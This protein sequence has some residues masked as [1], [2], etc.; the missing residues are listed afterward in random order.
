MKTASP[1][2]LK[3]TLA[4]AAISLAALTPMTHVQADE[5]L[6]F[7]NWSDY[8]AEETIARF[9]KETG[10]KV[11]YDVYDSNETLEAKLLAGN[12]GYDL[13]VPSSHFMALQIK[14]GIFQPLDKGKLSN[15]PHLDA[16]LMKT[17]QAKDPSNQYGVPYL[18]GTTGIGYNPKQVAEVL[19]EDAPVDSWELVFNPKYMEKLA[20]CGVTFLD[21]PDEMFSFAM[22]YAGMDPNSNKRADFKPSSPA[23]K[24]LKAVRPH[25]K[26]FTSSQYINDLA[27][28]DSCVA[29]GFSGD[30]FQA[31]AR[32]EE[33]NNGIEVAY[34]IPKEGT[35]IWFD[36]LLIPADAKNS[37]NAHKFI[38]YLM[39]PDVIAEITDYVWY[40]NPNKDATR[41]IDQE[42]A[43]NPAIYPTEET[44][45]N[46]FISEQVTPKIAKIRNRVWSDL[47][48]GR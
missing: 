6:N 46:L 3:K 38:N 14:A 4:T 25:I 7:Y 40:A 9:E 31:S 47:K 5:V 44:K 33:A 24:A 20:K 43:R 1:S 48:A 12:S 13:V 29:V 41:L 27:N 28:G 19:G 30:I 10:I 34:S 35:E 22:I 42:I 17:L 8:I 2:R 21:S 37:E 36:M 23:V 16:S 18:W 11:V 45:K 39:R 15:L 32:A 26:Q